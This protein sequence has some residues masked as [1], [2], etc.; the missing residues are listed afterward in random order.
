M[1]KNLFFI[2]LLPP[3]DIQQKVNLI[4]HHFANVY[5]SSA[6]LKSPPHITLQPPF[7]WDRERMVELKA[8]LAD[9]VQHQSSFTIILS[10]FAAFK[11]RVI[12]I[13]VDQT[14]ELLLL[15]QELELKLKSSLDIP[16]KSSKQYSFTPHMT[17]GFKDL[18]KVNFYQAWDEFKEASFEHKFTASA[19]TLLQ[20]NGK[21]WEIDTEFCFSQAKN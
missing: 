20:H 19:L 12:Y 2:A 17:V 3:L 4:K 1:N 14:P 16:H 10:G 9:F 8:V 13:S 6:A 5:K 18:T 21:N 7:H 15:Q 11:P